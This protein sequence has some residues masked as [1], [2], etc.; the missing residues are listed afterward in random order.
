MNEMLEDFDVFFPIHMKGLDADGKVK[1]DFTEHEWMNF[2][3]EQMRENMQNLSDADK[4]DFE[5][6]VAARTGWILINEKRLLVVRR[7][8]VRYHNQSGIGGEEE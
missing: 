5:R 8:G 6:L 2:N 3:E 4:Q 7:S 1:V